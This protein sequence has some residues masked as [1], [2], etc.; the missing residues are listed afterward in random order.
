VQN[1][2]ASVEANMAPKVE[3]VRV[4]TADVKVESKPVELLRSVGSCV[5]VCLRD[6]VLKCGG[7]AHV[8][9]SRSADRFTRASSIQ[10]CR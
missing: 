8:M 7:L 9:L 4:D 3:E 10:T 1:G 6:P 2:R 5:A